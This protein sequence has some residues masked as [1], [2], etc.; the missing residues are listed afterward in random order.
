MSDKPKTAVIGL[1]PTGLSCVRY[2]RNRD[3]P[4]AVTDSR[5]KPPALVELQKDFP[6]VP[7]S[8]G[9]FS[10]SFIGAADQLVVSPGVSIHEP[11]IA[12][13]MKKGTPVL[14]D[15]ELFALENK[16]PVLAI[17]GSNGKT[18]VTTLL[19][20]MVEA[21]G[22]EV[23]VC[24]NIGPQVLDA[25]ENASEY[26]VMELSSFQLETTY[27]LQTKAATV[28]NITPDHMDRYDDFSDYLAAKQ[29]IY[30][31]CEQPVVNLDE[32]ELWQ[33]LDL[34]NISGFTLKSPGRG[35]FGLREDAGR[36]YLAEGDL[37]LL[38]T[39]KLLLQGRHHFQNALAALSLGFA[40]GL[41]I[42]A[43]LSV[44]KTFAGI[45]HRCQFVAEK[46]G[47]HWFNDSKGTNVGATV[48]AIETLAHSQKGRLFLI[49][50]GDAKNADLSGLQTPLKE[51]VAQV[52]L[53]GQDADKIAAVIDCVTPY[54]RVDSLEA[55][56]RRAAEVAKPGDTVL[57]SPACASFDMFKNY[58][59]RGQTFID[60]VGQLSE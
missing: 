33:E 2:L 16:K 55:A 20:R 58:E 44:L 24:G 17:T 30:Q 45:S 13:Q 40:A 46:K 57:L 42:E 31:H 34:K 4:V 49:A 56:V 22:Y 29:R 14:G 26:Y 11:L 23:S 54:E 59:H 35:Q 18:T 9:E 41:P 5:E 25:L 39:D 6:E 43:M 28:L 36:L 52:M 21:S 7:V 60:L 19:G 53:F 51:S 38:A 15:V 47:V 1:G 10:P 48:A 8:L 37:L 27:S 32:P 3:C 50:G 12:E